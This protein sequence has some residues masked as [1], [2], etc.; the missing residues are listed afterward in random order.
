[1]PVVICL[2]RAVN[3]GG[4]NKI[5]M[6]VLRSL[7]ESLDLRDPQTYVQ[8]GNVIFRTK[9]RNLLR[10]S[11]RLQDSIEAR[12]GFRPEVILRTTAELRDVIARNPFATRRGVEPNKL[13]VNFLLSDPGAEARASVGG[14]KTDPEELC[15]DGRELYIY[16]PNGVG[17]SKLSM[18]KLEK[19][20]KTSGTARN[21]NTVTRLLD[22]AESLEASK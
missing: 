22:L 6:D 20:L 4:Y 19:A 10:V 21:W 12:C 16:F 15:M 7:C 17:R 1:M 13:I 11:K 14:L 2:L 3:L 9:E 18:T 5:K 8:S